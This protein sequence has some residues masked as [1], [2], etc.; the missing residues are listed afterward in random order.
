MR[1]CVKKAGALVQKLAPK[2]ELSNKRLDKS[3]LGGVVLACFDG[4][5]SIGNTA[6]AR[7]DLVMEQ[8]CLYLAAISSLSFII[9]TFVMLLLK[10]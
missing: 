10:A 3:V 5:I 6:A 9:K 2:L 7:L 1:S 8:V 4:Q